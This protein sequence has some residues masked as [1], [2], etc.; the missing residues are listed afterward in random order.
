MS[1]IYFFLQLGLR[2]VLIFLLASA[3]ELEPLDITIGAIL[4]VPS[5]GL[6]YREKLFI[7]GIEISRVWPISGMIS[8]MCILFMAYSIYL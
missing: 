2:L 7:S 6:F 1:K 8:V 4:F 5:G 3:I